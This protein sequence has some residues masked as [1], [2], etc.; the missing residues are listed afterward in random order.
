MLVKGTLV[1]HVCVT[2]LSHH[3]FRWLR[4]VCLAPRQHMIQCWRTHHRLDLTNKI[5]WNFNQNTKIFFAQKCILKRLR[6]TFCVCRN[7]W[8]IIIIY[9]VNPDDKKNQMGH[10]VE[11]RW[12]FCPY[13][14]KYPDSSLY[15]ATWK[16][17][18]TRFLFLVLKH[19]F[20]STWRV[21]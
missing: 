9:I 16:L 12:L 8:I 14:L 17:I 18:Y 4:V 20:H 15:L 21:W 5:R 11:F 6:Q 19:P 10:Q 7:V 1:T 13:F 2:E 3:W